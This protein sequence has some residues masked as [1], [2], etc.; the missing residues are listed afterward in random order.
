MGVAGDGWDLSSRFVSK[1]LDGRLIRL[2]KVLQPA[3]KN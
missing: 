2:V 3:D 1:A